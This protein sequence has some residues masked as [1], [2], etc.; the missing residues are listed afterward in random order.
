MAAQNPEHVPIYHP[1]LDRVS[2]V[3]QR[4][5]RAWRRAGWVPGTGPSRSR[6]PRRAP[7]VATGD[8]S[9][10]PAAPATGSDPAG[11]AESHAPVKEN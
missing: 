2:H 3:P 4:A 6:R 7:D 10:T 5:V 1:E 11:P 9:T 8:A